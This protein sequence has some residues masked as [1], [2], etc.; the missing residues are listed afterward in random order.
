MNQTTKRSPGRPKKQAQEAPVKQ[1]KKEIFK[2]FQTSGPIHEEYELLR[3]S[4]VYYLLKAGPVSVYDGESDSVR[5]IR[6]IPS[7][8]TIFAEE[9]TAKPMKKPIIFENGRLWVDRTKPNLKKFLNSHPGNE[10]N[11]G[12]IFRKIDLSKSAKVDLDTEFEVVDAL[13]L[14]RSQP[15]SDLLAVATA[16]GINTDRPS[17]EIKHDLLVFAK[18]NPKAFIGA[19]DNPAI[20]AK[21]KIKKAM[22]SGIISESKGHMVW[23]DTNKHIIAIPTGKEAADVFT[24][25]CMTEA[26]A[27]VLAEIERQL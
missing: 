18:K 16:F 8:Q 13:S 3:P 15:L 1:P 5:S 10:A 2:A 21:A 9:Q 26:G 23:T 19:F 14:L 12:N 6:Y 25:Y 24:R 20:D 4:G 11:G 17:D 22:S 7:E 27:P